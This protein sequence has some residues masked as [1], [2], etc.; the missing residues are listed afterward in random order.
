MKITEN[1]A[2]SS[3]TTM[4]LGGDAR[5]LVDIFS[6]TEIQEAFEFVRE[7]GLPYWLLGAGANTI[8]H[9]DGF[10]GVLIRNCIKGIS[11]DGDT[12]TAYGGEIWDDFVKYTAERGYTGIEAMSAIPGTV[13]AAPVQNIGAYGQEVSQTIESVKA[14]DIQDQKVVTFSRDE[15]NF[16]YRKSIFNS[17]DTAGK[18]LIISATFVLK[19]GDTPQPF[20]RSLQNYIDE[21]NIT[22]FSPAS[23]RECV[24]AIRAAKLPDP[25]EEASAGSF[26]KNVYLSDSEAD[27]AESRDIPVYRKS[28]P[29]GTH[30]NKVSSGWLIENAGLKGQTFHGFR[31][32]EKA[33]LILINDSATSYAD[34]EAARQEIADAV[35]AKFGIDIAQEPVEIGHA[36]TSV[37]KL[38]GG[39]ND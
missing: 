17:G 30:E 10:D 27:I 28:L 15:M 13:G 33:A 23:I 4:R 6:E 37:S 3:L 38:N 39:A 32:S 5:F 19:K 14:Y 9:D 7:Q 29:D 16:S 24:M 20:Y 18:Y 25:K 11:Q 1:V 31:V 21:N 34:L 26:F 2:I 35:R 36:E 22:D 12:F 8:G